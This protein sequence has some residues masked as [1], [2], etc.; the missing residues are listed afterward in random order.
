MWY[1]L[2]PISYSEFRHYLLL[3][4]TLLLNLFVLSLFTVPQRLRYQHSII[5]YKILFDFSQ[6]PSD[7]E[8]PSRPDVLFGVTGNTSTTNLE[9]FW[10][11]YPL[12]IL[13]V[14]HL[15]LAVWMVVEYFLTNYPH[16]IMTPPEIF[17]NLM[18]VDQIITTWY[19]LFVY[20]SNKVLCKRHSI[21]YPKPNIL[22]VNIL[23]LNTIWVL[24]FLICSVLSLLFLGYFYCICMLHIVFNNDILQRV[25]QSVTKNGTVLHELLV[26]LSSASCL[27]VNLC[28]GWHF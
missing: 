17:Y 5:N 4:I 6:R 26:L 15:F 24:L 11:R 12:Y 3:F 28:C 14:A 1:F 7:I 9:I 13:G 16:L 25:L 20:F 22:D 10:L 27:Q 23:G 18:W 2:L 8:N 21:E 19:V